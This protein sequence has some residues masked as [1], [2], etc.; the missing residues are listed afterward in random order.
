[1]KPYLTAITRKTLPAPTQYLLIHNLLI[2]KILDYGCGKCHEINN[3]FFEA[4]GYDPHFKP[5]YPTKQYD[6]IVCNYVL[7]VVNENKQ[8]EII[9]K[10]KNLLNNNGKAYLTVRRDMKEN[11]TT[12][13]TEQ[14]LVCFTL[15]TVTK[16]PNYEVYLL[17]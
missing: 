5:D 7:N 2:G 8:Q 1:L 17:Q 4:D 15:P 14:F 11:Y 12:K 13:N 9:D 16:N 10:I 3:Q 6:T